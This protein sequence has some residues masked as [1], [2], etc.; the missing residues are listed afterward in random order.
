M[1]RYF[2]G[3]GDAADAQANMNPYH[4]GYPV[5]VKVN[6]E[7]EAEV[8]KHLAMGRSA[9]ELAY[10]MPDRKTVYLT[11]DGTNVGLFMFIAD[12]AGD[13]SAGT[14]YAAKWNQLSG[15]GMGRARLGWV[16]LG[17][18]TATQ[19]Q[20]A[21]N[22]DTKFG[23]IFDFGETAGEGCA[24]VGLQSINSGHGSPYHEC[25]ALTG[26][27]SDAVASRLEMRRF[28]ALK[29]ATTEWRKME[30]ITFA[31][32]R[33]TLYLAMSEISNGML[34]K[35][36]SL[37]RHEGGNDHI[38]V[39]KND[40]GGVYSLRVG[41]RVRDTAG[42]M[43]DSRY[44]ARTM[45]GEVAG[46]PDSSVAGNSCDIN[47]IANPDNLSYLPRYNALVIG[48]DTGSGHQNDAVWLYNIAS[49][50]LTRIQTTP[51]GS[52]TTSVYWYPNLNGHAY[53][54]SVVQHPYGESDED[55][56]TGP[57]DERGYV[58]YFQFPQ[59]GR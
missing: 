45:Y 34:E 25:L 56:S 29:G 22:A 36:G 13:L 18:A 21:I 37:S 20:E 49:K 8:T 30:G 17:H 26:N 42:A 53:L 10:V 7:G 12:S 15:D 11:D 3:P 51:Y 50:D 33:R 43:I 40:C 59:L 35:S 1:A 14:L 58:G 19:V 2:G 24:D 54:M 41:G 32:E 27:V 57:D 55:K 52:E 44:A 9:L 48:E 6:A 16:N 23:D 31:P 46:T 47:G 4:Y 38:Q 28:A 5:E 39:E